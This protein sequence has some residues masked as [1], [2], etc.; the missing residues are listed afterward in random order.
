[1][2][3]ETV[4]TTSVARSLDAGSEEGLRSAD[5]EER[6]TPVFEDIEEPTVEIVVW[7]TARDEALK[8]VTEDT[9]VDEGELSPK[10]LDSNRQKYKEMMS[11]LAVKDA[12]EEEY[13]K[14]MGL[15]QPY[16]GTTRTV[17]QKGRFA[18]VAEKVHAV[19]FAG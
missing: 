8:K 15:M 12:T 6:G 7:N 5:K 9:I 11:S 10:V 18:K 17:L 3:H 13:R 2:G 1:M 4:V 14:A 19:Y 16:R